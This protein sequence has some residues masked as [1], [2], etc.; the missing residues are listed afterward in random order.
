MPNKKEGSPAP[1]GTDRGQA[2]TTQPDTPTETQTTPGIW[3]P[4]HPNPH[5]TNSTFT[6]SE[7]NEKSHGHTSTRRQ[8]H[9]IAQGHAKRGPRNKKL[10]EAAEE[11][12]VSGN[13]NDE[14]T[15]GGEDGVAEGPL[16]GVNLNL[17]TI[18]LQI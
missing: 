4:L 1:Q 10:I 18:N 6:S 13:P 16:Q 2:F 7:I 9:S 8:K 5:T 11:V 15:L 17:L 14:D 12:Y 3:Q